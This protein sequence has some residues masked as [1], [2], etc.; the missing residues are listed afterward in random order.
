MTT[1]ADLTGFS[2]LEAA[3]QRY[4]ELSEAIAANFA[5]WTPPEPPP[6]PPGGPAAAQPMP[7]AVNDSGP[8]WMHRPFREVRQEAA[9]I[10]Q[11]MPDLIPHLDRLADALERVAQGQSHGGSVGGGA[12]SYN[13]NTIPSLEN[14][15][16]NVMEPA[17]PV[18]DAMEAAGQGPIVPPNATRP[19]GRRASTPPTASTSMAAAMD[20]VNQAYQA[21]SQ[22]PES[23]LLTPPSTAT[24]PTAPPSPR[25][26][27]AIA[28]CTQ[29]CS[30]DLSVY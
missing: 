7:Q 26:V 27:P 4:K 25:D 16:Q 30:R 11:S 8:D 2:P 22:G 5:K 17:Q 10:G 3:L 13:L 1:E 9:S 12:G 28:D 20:R 29:W 23:P 18:I 14:W 24:D 15:V 19:Q 6:T 21:A